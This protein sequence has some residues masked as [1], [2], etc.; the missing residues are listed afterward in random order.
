[1]ELKKLVQEI[2][3]SKGKIFRVEFIKRTTGE[4]R[5]ML[6]RL[7]VTKGVTGKGLKFDP[8]KKAL[9]TVWDMQKQEWRMINLATVVSLKVAGKEVEVIS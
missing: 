5:V 7:G 3:N 6:C 9:M 1:M 4:R 8:A 2:K